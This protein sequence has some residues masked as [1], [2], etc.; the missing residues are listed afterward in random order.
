VVNAILRNYF[1]KY[2]L[3][4]SLLLAASDIFS[5]QYYHLNIIAPEAQKSILKKYSFKKEYKD[6]LTIKSTL[7]DLLTSLWK[8]GYIASSIDSVSRDSMTFTA[9]LNTGK[10][11]L[12]VKLKK[13]NTSGVLL[14]EAG[15]KEKMFTGKPVNFNEVTL[16]KEKILA[17]CEN[18]GYPFASVKLDS[19]IFS[20]SSLTASINVTKNKQ[21]VIDSIILRGKA[22]LSKAYLYNYIGVKPGDLYNESKVSQISKKIKEIQFLKETKPL[23]IFFDNS[24]AKIVIYAAKKKNS[25]FDG[26]IGLMPNNE[27]TRKLMLT[28]EANLNL[29][30]SFSRGEVINIK[31]DK[32]KPESQ[33]LKTDFT[34]PFLFNTPFGINAKFNLFKDDTLYLNVEKN[35]GL[36]YQFSGTNYI[37]AFFDNHTSSLIS[38][39]QYKYATVLP[40][41]A[42]M[43]SNMYGLEY[44]IQKLDYILNPQKGI[45]ILFSGSAGTKHILKN[46]ALSDS[47]YNKIKLNSTQYRLTGSMAFYIP[48]F[49]K[50]TLKLSMEAAT[51]Q[52]ANMF[53]ND[54]FLIGGLKTLRGF[55]EESIAASL[56]DIATVEYRY[57]FEQNSY[58]FAFWNGA[59]YES[60]TINNYIHDKPY[61]FG[62]G[63]SFETKAGIFSLSYALGKQFNNPINF[64]SAKIHFGIVS[65][66]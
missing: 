12:W 7:N 21:I 13:G 57:I 33:E 9:H 43:N 25:Q 40:D 8:D 55:D 48:L 2:Y 51:I 19:L 64:K 47:L 42:D 16:L 27:T 52:S 46:A 39:A 56:Y 44:K 58:L 18:N 20:D 15:Y 4:L 5:Q 34:Y 11:Y 41:Y 29:V 23:N 36:L 62:V 53:Q 45:D 24:K 31:W 66:F 60:K 49:L 10:K 35:I 54:L 6:T 65:Y 22:K 30:N 32:L 61:G 28:G 59:Y 26:I 63:V 17:Y 50:N 38:T 37:K 14:Q 3:L 1:L